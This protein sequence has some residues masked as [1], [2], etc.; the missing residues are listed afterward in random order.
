MDSMVPQLGDAIAQQ[1]SSNCSPRRM[2]DGIGF[3]PQHGLYP[4]APAFAREAP[5]PP[6]LWHGGATAPCLL[7]FDQ[8]WEY[9]CDSARPGSPSGSAPDSF[10]DA[11]AVQPSAA[12]AQG[13]E[14][15]LA[16]NMARTR[17]LQPGIEDLAA[18]ATAV[19]HAAVAAVI[20]AMQV[21]AAVSPLQPHHQR[22]SEL[23]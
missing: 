17:A 4:D 5:G 10:L 6:R 11:P 16:V 8:G 3:P 18:L 12:P 2:C 1:P 21:G 19:G 20:A 7:A 9:V 14:E 22:C 23:G 13:M 15:L